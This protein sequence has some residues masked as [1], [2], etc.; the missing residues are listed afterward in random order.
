M[1]GDGLRVFVL[2]MLT[3]GAAWA[4]GTI[5]GLNAS[6]IG[7]APPTP[8]VTGITSGSPIA[9]L[10]LYVSGNFNLATTIVIN[11]FD[12]TTTTSLNFA[13]PTPTLITAVVPNALFK[14]VAAQVPITITEVENGVPSNS[15]TFFVNPPLTPVPGPFVATVGKDFFTTVMTG[16]TQPYIIVPGALPP[17]F[18][19]LSTPG[20]VALQGLPNAAGVFTL[21][22]TV[23]DFWQT[24]SSPT[25]ILQI[26]DAAS[27]T[28]LVP[29]SAIAGSPGFTL[30]VNGNNF[31]Q[32]S[33]AQQLA[34][35]V[36]QWTFGPALTQLVTTFVSGNQLQATVP[37]NLVLSQG[38]A[39]VTSPAAGRQ[40]FGFPAIH[41]PAAGD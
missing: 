20:G 41:P 10:N 1:R 33:P 18:G 35:S 14:T 2:A 38:Q 9:S 29:S 7:G 6:Q 34:G 5:T 25:Q 23:T 40:R 11:W 24:K 12:G 36:V 26:V 30:Q 15:K 37:A 8:A 3:A 16:G 39:N 31:V 4:Q 17:G 32:A 13:N 19:M 22:P 27:L 21:T 28:S